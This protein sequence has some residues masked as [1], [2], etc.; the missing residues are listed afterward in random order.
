[1]I[2]DVRKVRH[3]CLG[4][5]F[6]IPDEIILD[7]G[8]VPDWHS[9]EEM[10]QVLRDIGW[11]CAGRRRN[12]DGIFYMW[13][14]IDHDKDLRWQVKRLELIDKRQIDDMN[15]IEKM[16]GLG[17]SREDCLKYLQMLYFAKLDEL[18]RVDDD[19]REVKRFAERVEIDSDTKYVPSRLIYGVAVMYY[20][21]KY[22][23]ER[24]DD[25][26]Y[27]LGSRKVYYT[28]GWDFTDPSYK[29]LEWLSISFAPHFLDLTLK[30]PESGE[31][32][33]F[34]KFVAE[35]FL[36][37][38]TLDKFFKNGID[39]KVLAAMCVIA[40][41]LNAGKKQIQPPGIDAEV[42][43]EL[44]KYVSRLKELYGG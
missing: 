25:Q 18:T 7:Q 34:K 24:M 43:I 6:V 35:T 30:Y 32:P 1:M 17:F 12:K 26:L 9:R 10:K 4:K 40:R 29:K 15:T 3:F 21:Q 44:I 23:P 5:D 19:E 11:E 39:Y 20:V 27:L 13:A 38:S 41:R 28:L 33:E 31:Y 36:T 42:A 2:F 14:P 16:L 8:K 22:Y 37:Q